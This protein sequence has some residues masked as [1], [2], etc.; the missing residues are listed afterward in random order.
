M[1]IVVYLVFCLFLFQGC[2]SPEPRKPVSRASKS[3]TNKSLKMNKAIVKK[4]ESYIQEL[5]QKDSANTYITSADGFW[6]YYNDQNKKDTLT[7]HFGD[8]VEFNYNLLTL[9]GDTIYS[10]KEIGERAYVIDQEEIFTGLRQGLKLMKEGE[11]LTFLFPSHQAYGYYGD[12]DKIGTHV[13]L[14]STVTLNKI[15]SNTD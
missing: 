4:E 1:K 6:Y 9:Q 3:F 14:K 15:K 5:I 12:N 10:R 8:E 11:T 13:A 7:P 2:K